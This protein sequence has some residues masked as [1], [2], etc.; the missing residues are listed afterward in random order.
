MNK[1]NYIDA[2]AGNVVSVTAGAYQYDRGSKL[3]VDGTTALL[4]QPIR[5]QKQFSCTGS[6]FLDFLLFSCSQ[7]RYDEFLVNVYPTTALVY[8]SI[9]FPPFL[10]SRR[11]SL[12]FSIFLSVLSYFRTGQFVVQ[13]ESFLLILFSTCGIK[14]GTTFSTVPIISYVSSFV[15]TTGHDYFIE[16]YNENNRARHG[17]SWYCY[18]EADYLAFV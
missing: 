17:S 5:Q 8:A 2:I 9:R 7:A 10:V 16:T 18:C 6:K 4:L 1:T 11:R 13:Q 3:R 12:S 14:K 15:V